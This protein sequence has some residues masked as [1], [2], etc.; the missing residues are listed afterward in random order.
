MLV[1]PAAG[2]RRREAAVQAVVERVAVDVEPRH[3]FSDLPSAGEALSRA[4]RGV[5]TAPLDGDVVVD[6]NGE[7]WRAAE[8]GSTRVRLSSLLRGAASEIVPAMSLGDT[9]AAGGVGRRVPRRPRL[10][11]GPRLERVVIVVSSSEHGPV[12]AIALRSV[13]AG[14]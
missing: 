10:R 2:A 12:G 5:I 7:L 4:L 1:E 3:F 8:W 9:G 11:Q 14:G 13:E 6:L